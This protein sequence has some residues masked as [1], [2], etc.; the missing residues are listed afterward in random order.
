MDNKLKMAKPE[1][2][3]KYLRGMNYTPDT[4]MDKL[5]ELWWGWYIRDNDYYKQP[6]VINDNSQSYDRLS[7]RP[8]SMV[9]EEI[10]SLVM[11][12]GT[13]LSSTDKDVSAWLELTI[14]DFVDEQAEF[15]SNVFALGSGAWVADFT[16][17]QGSVVT[18]VRRMNAWQVIPLI[19][20]GCAFVSK[21]SVS[22]KRY[23]QLQI[24]TLS[25]KTGTEVIET[26]LFDPKGN[27]RRVIELDEVTRTLDTGQTFP[28][29]AIVKPAKYNTHDE[30][31]P[32]GA[33]LLEDICDT[34]RLIDEVF[35]QLYWQVKVSLPKMIVDEQA[36]VR[37]TK[38]GKP[39]FAET[40]NQLMFAP[41][42]SGVGIN[43]PVTVY[44]PDTHIDDMV[45]AINNA[46]GILGQRTG[47]GAGYWSF[48]LGQGLKTATEVVSAN[49][50][51]MRTIRRHEHAIENSVRDLVQGAYSAECSLN[52][53]LITEP[54]PVDI[55]WDDSVI[56]DDKADRDMMKDDIA[57]GLCPK[58][59]YLTKYQGMSE[60]EAKTYTG[61]TS[62]VALDVEIGE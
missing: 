38:T 27:H 25:R 53:H 41:I 19:G 60:E 17:T 56:T 5:Q 24:R 29:Y 44:N 52:G 2:A 31:T 39:V 46:L 37:D 3:V 10:P 35:N 43:V 42:K 36:L 4:S 1:W 33:S 34:C 23:D 54:I 30:L 47:F 50:Q 62:G 8:A 58:W 20:D 21:V 45:T 18:T 16:G 14:P 13:I 32:L 40:M 15:M 6:Y 55:L 28:T 22:G 61:E 48:T 12:E 59:K 9:A 57:R 51:L 7:M 11:N 26:L 49:S